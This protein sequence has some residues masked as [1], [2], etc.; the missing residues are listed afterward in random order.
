MLISFSCYVA[1]LQAAIHH[2]YV[3]T[4]EEI[5]MRMDAAMEA[6]SCAV[7]IFVT[8]IGSKPYLF[9]AN[10]GDCRAVLCSQL[11]NGTRR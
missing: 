4:N 9:C 2:A 10:A 1:S 7:T 3:S 5:G 8:R 11:P 6:G